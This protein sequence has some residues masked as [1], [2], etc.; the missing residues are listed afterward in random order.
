MNTGQN[1]SFHICVKVFKTLQLLSL[2]HLEVLCL[3]A[4]NPAGNMCWI[5]KPSEPH[6]LLCM[7]ITFHKKALFVAF[8]WRDWDRIVSN[9]PQKDCK[10][11]Q[12]VG[13]WFAAFEVDILTVL[14]LHDL[15][16][17][18]GCITYS[19]KHKVTV[20]MQGER[21]AFLSNVCRQQYHNWANVFRQCFPQ[22]AGPAW[23]NA[24]S[25]V[26]VLVCGFLY[27]LPTVDHVSQMLLIL[28]WP[29]QQHILV[30]G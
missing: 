17:F 4:R 23:R 6:W 18:Q 16:I 28:L 22:A 14:I 9:M 12:Q 1:E 8:W 3:Y 26:R 21:S 11:L 25:P 20:R 5:A 27:L 29:C 7:E 24:L 13:F 30:I 2:L 10:F 15:Q 19:V